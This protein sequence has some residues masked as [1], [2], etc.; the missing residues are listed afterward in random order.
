MLRIEEDGGIAVV[1]ID[2]PEARNAL[3]A[4]TLSALTDTARTLGRRSDISAVI[5]TGTDRFFSAGIDL[6]AEPRAS[7]TLLER[8][9]AARAGPDLCRA[10]EAI[11]AV[12]IVAIEGYCVGGA[13]ALALACDSVWALAAGWAR[14]WFGRSPRRAANLAASGGVMMIGLGGVLAVTGAKE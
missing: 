2:R 12:T 5:L 9:D 10:W 14:D 6:K 11:E 1:R 7:A 8:R 3:N 4:E 13:C